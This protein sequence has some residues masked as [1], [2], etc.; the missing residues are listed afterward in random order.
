VLVRAVSTE[1][2]TRV[3]ETH[4]LPGVARVRATLAKEGTCV[5]DVLPADAKK[6]IDALAGNPKGPRL[7][8][9]RGALDR[10]RL[11]VLIAPAIQEVFVR[12]ISRIAQPGKESG[13]GGATA[14]AAQLLGKHGRDTGDRLRCIGKSVAGGHGVDIEAK[15]RDAARDYSQGAVSVFDESIRRRIAT[16]EGQAIIGELARGVV[17]HILT[18]PV[19]TIADDLDRLSIADVLR[20]APSVIAYAVEHE[21][22]R[23]IFR[24]EVRAALAIEGTRTFREVLEEAGLLETLHAHLVG[25]GDP[26][27]RELFASKAFADWVDALL[28]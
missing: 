2:A 21:P 16:D 19:T 24:E 15:L 22:V 28:S 20:V 7:G 10:D 18:T 11:H 9:L 5:G 8:W 26:V 25:R 23:S 1:N 13:T 4:V 14:A 27:I 12:F 6:T 17:A 3:I